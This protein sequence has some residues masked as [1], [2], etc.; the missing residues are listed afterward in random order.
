MVDRQ[1]LR[2]G[3]RG[4]DALAGRA[5]GGIGTVGVVMGELVVLING[6]SIM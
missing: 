5:L 2:G 1:P 6:T 4:R 3:S